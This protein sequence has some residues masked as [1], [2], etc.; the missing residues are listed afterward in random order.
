MTV[1]ALS[2]RQPWAWLIVYGHKDVENRDWRYPCKYRGPI[3]VHAGQ[4]FDMDGY[5]WVQE[6][7]PQINMPRPYA[8]E[9]GGIVGRTEI[10]DCTT[11]IAS[12]WFF[13]K[14]GLVLQNSA[15]LQFTPLKGQLGLF[16]VEW[17]RQ[18]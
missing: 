11:S 17:T 3:L 14:Y 12:P 6:R 13:G 1:K 5:E 18:P 10:I 8:F 16:N 7:F 15:P 2:I 4:R 9:T